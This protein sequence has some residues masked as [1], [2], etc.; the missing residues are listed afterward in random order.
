MIEFRAHEPVNEI[1]ARSLPASKVPC[2]HPEN[3]LR[4]SLSSGPLRH[5]E[6]AKPLHQRRKTALE[7]P[8]AGRFFKTTLQNTLRAGNP[9][10]PGRRLIPKPCVAVNI[11]VASP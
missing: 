8:I 7:S 5:R 2:R 11:E 6:F 3:S 1:R 4:A 9:A 10:S